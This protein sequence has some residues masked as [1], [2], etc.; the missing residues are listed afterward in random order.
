MRA[1]LPVVLGGTGQI[2]WVTDAEGE[3]AI[4]LAALPGSAAT[5]PAP[6]AAPTTAAP[7]AAPAARRI[8]AGQLGQVLE[9]VA[10]RDGHLLAAAA[11]DG[12]LLLVHTADGEVR[13]LARAGYGP[14]RGLAFSPTRAGWP[15]PSRSPGARCAGSGCSAWTCPTRCR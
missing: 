2:A 1:R 6:T 9:L 8:A 11:G 10:S 4:E 12:R 13:E 15:G 5:H 3:D 7:T 14:I